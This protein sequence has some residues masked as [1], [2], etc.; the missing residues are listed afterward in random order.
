MK[1][2]EQLQNGNE[3]EQELAKEIKAN[4]KKIDEKL[5]LERVQK[6]NS[7]ASLQPDPGTNW[8]LI[9]GVGII[10]LS[11]LLMGYFLLNKK[12]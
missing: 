2:R 4:I 5:K 8:L 6:N 12:G 3:E 11:L 9:G 1:Q 7:S 10:L